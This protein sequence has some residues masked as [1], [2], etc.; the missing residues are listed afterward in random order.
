MIDCCLTSNEQYFS[1]IHD[2]NL[3]RNNKMKAKGGS[4]IDQYGQIY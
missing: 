3:F 4:E 2:E 1:Y